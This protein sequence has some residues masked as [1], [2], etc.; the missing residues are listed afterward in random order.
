M[1]GVFHSK[2]RDV[3]NRQELYD[4]IPL[5]D[6]VY[7][8][9]QR[10]NCYSAELFVVLNPRTQGFEIHS[11]AHSGYLPSLE[12]V[13]P[14]K[15]LDARAVRYIQKNDIR[16]HGKEIFRRIERSEELKAKREERER[17]DT[18]RAIAGETQS[19]FAKDAWSF[20]T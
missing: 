12:C 13:L 11:L 9:P 4:L 3:L 19:M 20:G 5:Y 7:E 18:I 2:V 16:I 14:Y 15:N 17:R 1:D 10:V 8:I 6:S